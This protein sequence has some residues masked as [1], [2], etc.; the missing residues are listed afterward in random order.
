MAYQ[1]PDD[2]T[3]RIVFA[4]TAEEGLCVGASTGRQRRRRHAPGPRAGAR[5]HDRDDPVRQ[6]HALPVAAVQP[7]VSGR[8]VSTR[9]RLAGAP[10]RRGFRQYLAPLKGGLARDRSPRSLRGSR[11]LP[12]SLRAR[13]ASRCP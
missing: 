11:L 2:E 3:L 7:G 13:L 8:Q 10:A 5:S 12:M 4:L 9:T 6:R 1:I